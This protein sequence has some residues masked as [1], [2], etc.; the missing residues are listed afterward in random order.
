MQLAD[1]MMANM[2]KMHSADVALTYA[3]GYAAPTGGCL[4][5]HYVTYH[6]GSRLVPERDVAFFYHNDATWF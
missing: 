4:T 6:N 2:H 1:G 5:Y 3:R